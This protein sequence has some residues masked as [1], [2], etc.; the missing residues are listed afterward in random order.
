MQNSSNRAGSEHAES[1][2]SPASSSSKKSFRL[3]SLTPGSSR[4]VPSEEALGELRLVAPN[5]F[6]LQWVKDR[7]LGRIEA[8]L[9]EQSGQLMRVVLA[10]PAASEAPSADAAPARPRAAPIAPRAQPERKSAERVDDELGVHLRQFRARA[11]PTSSRAPPPCRSPR[12]PA[13]PTTRSSSTAA[14]G[15]ARRTCCTRSATTSAAQPA[16]GEGALPAR[17]TSTSPTS[18][19]PTSRSRS[20]RSSA[21]T[22]RS[23]CC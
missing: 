22:T 5:R 19:A 15:S 17:R 3:S 1:S 4:C 21:T 23:T 20:T 12:I 10:L 6:V 18:S 11:R 7:F 8:M 16:G 14:P 9:A 2:G 13:P